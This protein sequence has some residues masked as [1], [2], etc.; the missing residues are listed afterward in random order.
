MDRLYGLHLQRS[1]PTS[2][3]GLVDT[4]VDLILGVAGALIAMFYIS[5]RRNGIIG[6]DKERI[7]ARKQREEEMYAEKE[8]VWRD[9]VSKQ[10]QKNSLLSNDGYFYEMPDDLTG[11]RREKS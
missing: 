1:L 8:R 2:D 4:M 10:E 5:F 7:K 9:Y 3:S 11:N 6:R